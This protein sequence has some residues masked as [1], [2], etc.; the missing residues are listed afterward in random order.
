MDVTVYKMD[1]NNE[2]LIKLINEENNTFNDFL[3]NLFHFMMNFVCMCATMCICVHMQVQEILKTAS[4]T[5]L[6]STLPL[7]CETDSL[8]LY[9]AHM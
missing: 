4:D 8:P 6:Y 5:I 9:K 1:T 3:M 2:F 7:A